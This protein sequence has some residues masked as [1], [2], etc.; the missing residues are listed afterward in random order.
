[1]ATQTKL[2]DKLTEAELT[3]YKNARAYAT[4]LLQQLGTLEL[5]KARL[6][7]DLNANEANAQK[8]LEGVRSRLSLDKDTP[9]Q[10]NED[11]AVYI[12]SEESTQEG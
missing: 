12:L 1:M 11:G 6:V 5:R 2:V 3:S 9:W 8:L 10:I 4:Q 7:G